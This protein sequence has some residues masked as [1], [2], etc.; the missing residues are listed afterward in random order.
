MKTHKEIYEELSKKLSPEELV[1][2]AYVSEKLSP[3]EHEEFRKLRLERLKSM[4]P[5]E[6]LVS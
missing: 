3:E 6:V 4:S 2:S 5:Q 1:E